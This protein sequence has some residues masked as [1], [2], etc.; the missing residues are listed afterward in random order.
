MAC[1][2]CEKRRAVMRQWLN[3]QT[4]FLRNLGVKVSLDDPPPV[5]P[6][7]KQTPPPKPKDS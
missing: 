5:Q 1:E 2:G 3:E 7:D 4:S 6:K